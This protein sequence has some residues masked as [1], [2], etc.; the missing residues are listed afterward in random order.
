[1][2]DSILTLANSNKFQPNSTKASQIL[3]SQPRRRVTSN[4]QPHVR[5]C[6]V[7]VEDMM[8]TPQMPIGANSRRAEN[9]ERSRSPTLKQMLY[10][11]KAQD[12]IQRASHDVTGERNRSL[13]ADPNMS[14]S[15]KLSKI[16]QLLSPKH[17]N[18]LFKQTMGGT[19]TVSET[20]N[21]TRVGNDNETSHH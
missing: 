7:S 18:L 1:M 19:Q 3:G 16:Q 2:A 12:G 13:S 6:S 15:P 14:S 8:I 17:A 5:E 21:V 4:H 11:D 20:T 10:T 9:K